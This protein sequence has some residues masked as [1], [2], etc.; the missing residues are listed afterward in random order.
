MP[1]WCNYG[2]TLIET[3]KTVYHAVNNR[4]RVCPLGVIGHVICRIN[5]GAG[6]T[7]ERNGSLDSLYLSH[8]TEIIKFV[9][10]VAVLFSRLPHAD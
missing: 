9:K 10:S 5:N 8:Q 2:P 3:V 7:Q 4:K 1:N 6:G